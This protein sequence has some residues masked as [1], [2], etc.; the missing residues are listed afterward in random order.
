MSSRITPEVL[1]Q[2]TLM[3]DPFMCD[4][5]RD[6]IPGTQFVL[7]I[8]MDKPDLIVKSVK[9]QHMLRTADGF[10]YIRLDVYAVDSDGRHYDIEVQ[11]ASALASPYRA[12]HNSAVLDANLLKSGEDPR[13]LKERESVV[14]FITD[15]DVLGDD[16]PIYNI[17]RMIEKSGKKFND[18]S[19]IVYVN[20]SH[21]DLNTA[22]G[23]LMH[24][25]ECERPEEMYYSAIADKAKQLK[26][27][28]KEMGVWAEIEAVAREEG[29]N[30]GRAT[31]F[32]EAEE[33]IA[34][35]LI[36]SGAVALEQIAECCGL[37]LQRV[38][39]LADSIS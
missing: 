24:D 35:K 11:N 22:L 34:Q 28:D 23:K 16:E 19:Y 32:R 18:G 13:I 39:E 21:Q 31:G 2:A 9:V 17:I 15:K 37:T 5:F 1:E 6:N 26:G 3:D 33:T 30:E 4:F 29:F 10:R 36:K 12:R 20:S 14:I 38:K 8:I 25:F 7:R 27:G